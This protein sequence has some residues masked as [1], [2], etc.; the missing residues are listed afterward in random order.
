V[1]PLAW[2]YLFLVVFLYGL[3]FYLEFRR[4]AK[5]HVKGCP[6]LPYISPG[7]LDS[8]IAIEPD[9]FIVDLTSHDVSPELLQ[10]PDALRVPVTQLENF[11]RKA[12]CR[13][14]FVFYDSAAD[15][16]K[17]SRVESIVNQYAIRNVYVLKGGLEFWLSKH[18]AS[19]MAVT[20]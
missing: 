9:L 1:L 13:S 7:R 5:R 6:S 18:Q 19:G 3:L 20:S 16:V 8:L 12:S 2:F 14:I 15:P 10:I 17:W 4:R 11:L